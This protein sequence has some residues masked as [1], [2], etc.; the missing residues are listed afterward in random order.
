MEIGTEIR[1]VRHLPQHMGHRGDI[2]V[3]FALEVVIEQPFRHPSDRG[4]V[5][6][7]DL[8]IGV[9]GE[10]TLARREDALEPPLALQPQP[11][12]SWRWCCIAEQGP[13][14]SLSARE[15]LSRQ[16]IL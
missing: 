11:L 15:V 16:A 7:S 10:E 8:V 6:D 1:E 2:E 9:R 13:S 3:V 12:R 14:V 4:E 5:L